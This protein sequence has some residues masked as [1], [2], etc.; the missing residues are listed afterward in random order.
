M[1]LQLNTSVQRLTVAGID[2]GSTL[3]A[4]TWSALTLASGMITPHSN[5]G[6]IA[7]YAII[8]G[9]VHLR[10]AIGGEA[11]DYSLGGGTI[12]LATL[13]AEATPSIQRITLGVAYPEGGSNI[14]SYG[15]SA[16]INVDTSGNVKY[17]G[18]GRDATSC[19]LDGISYS[20]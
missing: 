15:H 1:E 12:T 4:P 16:R 11:G 18:Q 6:Y 17:L 8:A 3:A 19:F 14:T 13:P 7:E 10:G 9:I 2:V 20:L 5:N